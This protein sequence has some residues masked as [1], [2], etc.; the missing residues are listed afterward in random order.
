MNELSP[1]QVYGQNQQ[2]QGYFGM[3]ECNSASDA[4]SFS[5]PAQVERGLLAGANSNANTNSEPV[6][7]TMQ[8]VQPGSGNMVYINDGQQQ[9]N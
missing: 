2:P 4:K 3:V 9:A 6:L 5:T 1:S 7:Q 8:G